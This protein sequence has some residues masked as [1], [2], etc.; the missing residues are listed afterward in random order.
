MRFVDQVQ[1]R[2][3]AGDGG[4]GARSFRREKYVPRGGPDGGDGGRGGD[5]VLV[6]DERLHTLVDLR[7]RRE[8]RA[9]R[10][11][12]G[13]G[14]NMTG[15]SGQSLEL[16]VPVG[17][18]VR[19]LESGEMLADLVADAQQVVIARGG[20]GGRGNARFQTSTNRTPQRAE[21][22][23]PGEQREVELELKLLADVGLAGLPN[24][25]KSTL[26]SRLSAARPRIADYPF[27]TLEPQLGVV[28]V[29]ELQSFVMADIPG[30]IEGASDGVGLGHQFLRHVERTAVIVQ[31]ID[32]AS[33]EYSVAEA[34]EIIDR[35]LRAYSPEIGARPRLLVG[36]KLDACVD[37]HA[38]R[39]LQRIGERMQFDSLCIS[40]ITGDNLNVLVRNIWDRIV[41]E[42]G[43][44]TDGAV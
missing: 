39:E 25:G 10:G 26:I 8:Y 21:D 35:E 27:T 14:S 20:D 2:T 15:K 30:L 31:M 17:T 32:L 41:L 7:Y 28:R 23:W 38:Q 16:R 6:A 22:G 12:H 34:F 3:I 1:L 4:C 43:R 18:L 24:A 40:S 9:E 13:R 11:A 36:T 33:P 44:E 19:D 5:V 42:R 29:D 37:D